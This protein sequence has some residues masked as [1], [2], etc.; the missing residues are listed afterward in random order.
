[1]V[2]LRQ[3]QNVKVEKINNVIKIEPMTNLHLK[4]ICKYI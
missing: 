1:M 2:P 3:N 4:D